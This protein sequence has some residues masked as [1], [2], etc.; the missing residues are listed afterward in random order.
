MGTRETLQSQGGWG[1]GLFYGLP[2]EASGVP[3]AK[4]RSRPGTFAAVPVLAKIAGESILARTSLCFRCLPPTP[5]I[6]L[7]LVV[8]VGRR[9]GPKRLKFY[10]VFVHFLNKLYSLI[11]CWLASCDTLKVFQSLQLL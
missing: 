4:D 10:L 11:L 2:K 5:H 1:P 3:P 8:V 9:G 6:V 7:P